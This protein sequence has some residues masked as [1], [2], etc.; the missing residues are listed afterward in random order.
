MT[1]RPATPIAAHTIC[2]MPWAAGSALLKYDRTLDAEY[3]ITIPIAVSAMT[4]SRRA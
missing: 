2:S 3:T 4:A 1:S